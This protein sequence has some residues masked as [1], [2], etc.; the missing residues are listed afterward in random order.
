MRDFKNNLLAQFSVI[1]FAIMVILG[2]VVSMVLIE[3]L[4]RNIELM[5]DH[6]S[7]LMAGRA[8]EPSDPFSIESLS[9]K[10]SNLKWI[11]L[12][13]IG[14]SFVYLY[15]TLVYMVWEGAPRSA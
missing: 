6:S 10:V 12:A 5:Q 8:I 1:T 15:G 4:N 11:T 13:A 7:A 2:L 14:G 9:K 3:M